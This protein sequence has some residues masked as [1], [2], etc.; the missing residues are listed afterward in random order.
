M[1][2]ALS[3][4]WALQ[5]SASYASSRPRIAVCVPERAWS[6]SRDALEGV[7]HLNTQSDPQQLHLVA[8]GEDLDPIAKLN[9]TFRGLYGLNRDARIKEVPLIGLT[10]IG[11]GEIFRFEYGQQIKSYRPV[12]SIPKIKGL[13]HSVLG[14]HGA[15][16]LLRAAGDAKDAHETVATISKALEEAK[17]R[18]LKELPEEIV[19]PATRVLSELINLS[20]GWRSGKPATADD[21]PDALGRVQPYLQQVI[22]FTGVSAYKSLLTSFQQF[23]AET[24]PKELNEYIIGVCGPG[25]GRRDNIEIAAAAAVM[26]KD[27]IGLRLFYLENAL[28]IPDGL[29]SVASILIEKSLGQAVFNDPYRMWRDLLADAAVE[30]FGASFFPQIGR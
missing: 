19:E 26:G 20:D 18:A 4:I 12:E 25:Q 7:V 15:W 30:G 17:L 14:A 9:N 28:T 29:K 2:T 13:M 11:T 27:A 10:L 3:I 6:L 22:Q 23:H 8:S 16:G 5:S 1:F 21:F 24:N